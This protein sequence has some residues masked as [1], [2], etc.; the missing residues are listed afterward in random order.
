MQ[1]ITRDK[2][3]PVFDRRLLP[4]ARVEPGE[5]FV[6]ETEDSRGGR[7]RVRLR[8]RACVYSGVAPNSERAGLPPGYRR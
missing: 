4:V 3:T 2:L 8:D 5:T 7:T 1:R 6:I